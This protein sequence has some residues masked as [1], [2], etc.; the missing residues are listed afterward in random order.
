MPAIS[1]SELID[2]ILR[3]IQKSGGS[4][5]YMSENPATDQWPH[6]ELIGRANKLRRIQGYY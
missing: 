5:F 2:A 6:P 3:A 1:P 4:G